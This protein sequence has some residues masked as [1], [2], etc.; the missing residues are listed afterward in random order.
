MIKT[1]KAKKVE[2]RYSVNGQGDVQI[3]VSPT[4]IRSDASGKSCVAVSFDD[5][6]CFFEEIMQLYDCE[7]D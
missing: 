3:M 4:D 1:L 2:F 5:L 7:N 6:Y